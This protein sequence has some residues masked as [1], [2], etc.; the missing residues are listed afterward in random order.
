LGYL[1]KPLEDEIYIEPGRLKPAQSFGAR[2]AYAALPFRD[3][4]AAG[5]IGIEFSGQLELRQSAFEALLSE[6]FT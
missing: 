6:A 5:G 3:D 1:V 2:M 4:E